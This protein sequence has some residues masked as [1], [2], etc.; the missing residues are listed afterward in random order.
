[1]PVLYIGVSLYK[2]KHL[3]MFSRNFLISNSDVS[4]TGNHIK[5]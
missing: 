4:G 5:K 3:G 1:M 2:T